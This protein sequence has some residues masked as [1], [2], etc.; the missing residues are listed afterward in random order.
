M[1]T[2]KNSIGVFT[3]K[4]VEIG[5][6]DVAVAVAREAMDAGVSPFEFLMKGICAGLANVGKKFFQYQ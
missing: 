6:V 5:D 4:A 1:D 2:S 3:R